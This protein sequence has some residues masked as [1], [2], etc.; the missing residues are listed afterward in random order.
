M[1]ITNATWSELDAFISANP[2]LDAHRG[3]IVPRNADEGPWNHTLDLHI[4]QD[5]PI[6]NTNLQITLDILNFWNLID[7]DSGTLRFVNFA[8]VEAW[9][10]EG[11]ADDGTPIITLQNVA[12]GASPFRTH[13][14]RSRW[15]AKLGIRW[16]F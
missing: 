11:L 5:I 4:A 15:R 2:V 12:Q 14:T 13:N 1:I 9:E 8:A 6:K 3:G 7:E 16:T 10:F